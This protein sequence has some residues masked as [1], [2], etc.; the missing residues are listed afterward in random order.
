MLGSFPT[1]NPTHNSCIP[2]RLAPRFGSP[3]VL[4]SCKTYSHGAVTAAAAERACLDRTDQ[5]PD[6]QVGSSPETAFGEIIVIRNPKSH[7][8]LLYSK[9]TV[10]KTAPAAGRVST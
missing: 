2:V 4:V 10:S 9:A 8:L 3:S 7:S 6:G 1:H 5:L